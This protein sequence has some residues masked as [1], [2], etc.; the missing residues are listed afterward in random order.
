[1]LSNINQYIFYMILVFEY[2]YDF[3]NFFDIIISPMTLCKYCSWGPDNLSLLSNLV[4]VR[5]EK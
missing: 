5:W 1:M 2:A 3:Y 4:M